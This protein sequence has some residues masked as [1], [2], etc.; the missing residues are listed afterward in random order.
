MAMCDV[1]LFKRHPRVI[2]SEFYGTASRLQPTSYKQH[3]D[4]Q[5]TRQT[6]GR[7]DGHFDYY[8]IRMKARQMH[9]EDPRRKRLQNNVPLLLMQYP[10]IIIEL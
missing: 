9:P 6:I 10:L 1:L 7:T 5:P 8:A 3:L 4:R 2:I